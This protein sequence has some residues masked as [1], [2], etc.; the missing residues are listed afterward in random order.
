MNESIG[1]LSIP[2]EADIILLGYY[3]NWQVY[4]KGGI[5]AGVK[6]HEKRDVYKRQG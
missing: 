6:I 2:L 3:S 1:Y 5:Q 4:L